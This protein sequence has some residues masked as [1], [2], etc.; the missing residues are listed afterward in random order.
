MICR[1]T[2]EDLKSPMPRFKKVWTRQKMIRGFATF[3]FVF[4]SFSGLLPLFEWVINSLEYYRSVT[5]M[6]FILF[7]RQNLQNNIFYLNQVTPN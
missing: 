2:F 6:K 7:Y 5:I 4:L 3:V 1:R